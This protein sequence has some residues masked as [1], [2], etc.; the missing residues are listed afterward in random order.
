MT[1]NSGDPSS[2]P[3]TDA[4][5]F[6]SE[7]GAEFDAL[8]EAYETARAERDRLINEPDK[9]IP[10]SHYLAKLN[11]AIAAVDVAHDAMMVAYHA[12]RIMLGVPVDQLP[13]DWAS[14][15]ATNTPIMQIH[16][17]DIEHHARSFNEGYEAAVTQ[18]LAD[19]PKLADDWFQDKIREAKQVAWHGGYIAGLH[20]MEFNGI[21]IPN[22]YRS[23]GAGE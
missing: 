8:R 19:D 12:P 13:E 23:A 22:P 7:Q 21:P 3:L 16:H 17:H 6:A 18:G 1:I 14:I 15:A 2:A 5:G 9:S 4:G 11:A 10:P 20:N